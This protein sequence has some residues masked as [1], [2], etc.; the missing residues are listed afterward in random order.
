MTKNACAACC[1]SWI[2]NA[3]GTVTRVVAFAT[4][5]FALVMSV[6]APTGRCVGCDQD[7]PLIAT[8]ED[9]DLDFGQLLGDD[10]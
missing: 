4:L 9:G 10:E 5:R 1:E 6:D 7:R 3:E 2:G 8:L